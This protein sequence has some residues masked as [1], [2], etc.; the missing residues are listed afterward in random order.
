MA[1]KSDRLME[2]VARNS[3]IVKERNVRLGHRL[4]SNVRKTEEKL[5]R[6]LAHYDRMAGEVRRDMLTTK[7]HTESLGDYE[8]SSQSVADKLHAVELDRKR[9]RE[10]EQIRHL[11]QTRVPLL[12]TW[13]RHAQKQLAERSKE[14]EE[15]EKRRE[16]VL[17][18]RRRAKYLSSTLMESIAMVPIQD[19][20]LA[21][22]FVSHLTHDDFGER[23]VF[24][25]K[26]HQSVL[27]DGRHSESLKKGHIVLLPNIQSHGR[28]ILVRQNRL[29]LAMGVRRQ[30]ISEIFEEERE[31]LPPV[32]A[33][34][35][36]SSI[37][38][39][40][41]SLRIEKLDQ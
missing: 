23:R 37:T 1:T 39:K 34:L 5:T 29:K 21:N 7:L 9:Q 30:G 10:E 38:T 13:A 17:R 27:S 4:R 40:P 2:I 25:A 31:L 12:F 14:D 22:D 41:Q 18:R 16:K 32:P 3:M 6:Q 26:S 11:E 35:M 33:G 19:A 8:R 36:I 20:D 28:E 15:Q 24:S